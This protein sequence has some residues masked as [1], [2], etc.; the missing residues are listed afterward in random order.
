MKYE[1]FPPEVILWSFHA[2]LKD[3]TKEVATSNFFQRL[4]KK[5]STQLCP[6]IA[7]SFPLE[8]DDNFFWNLPMC[9]LVKHILLFNCMW[10]IAFESKFKQKRNRELLKIKGSTR[11]APYI[12]PTKLRVS[13]DSCFSTHGN[14]PQP[15]ILSNTDFSYLQPYLQICSFLSFSRDIHKGRQ[16]GGY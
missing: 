11:K 15:F 3:C 2:V 10:I 7:I 14:Y 5:E 9:K 8:I 4:W 13:K 16:A 1:S 12:M 6:Q